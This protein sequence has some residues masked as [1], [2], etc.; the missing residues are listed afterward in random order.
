MIFLHS[1]TYPVDCLH[2]RAL[3]L[4]SEPIHVL[5]AIADGR[6]GVTPH[7]CRKPLSNPGFQ[8]HSLFLQSSRRFVSITAMACENSAFVWIKLVRPNSSWTWDVRTCAKIPVLTV[9]ASTSRVSSKRD[10][11]ASISFRYTGHDTSLSGVSG[12]QKGVS[13]RGMRPG[14]HR[15]W[16][17]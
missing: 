6:L 12:S 14:R 3:F 5:L 11:D 4:V 8:L 15:R 2:H 17:K 16:R 13:K 10:H 9:L 7:A 1:Y